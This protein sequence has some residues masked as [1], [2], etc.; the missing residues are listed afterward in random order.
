[1]HAPVW[2]AAFDDSATPIRFIAMAG[3]AVSERAQS[4]LVIALGRVSRPNGPPN[5]ARA[6]AFARDTGAVVWSA[7][8]PSPVLD[9]WSSPVIDRCNGTVL[10]ASNRFLTA[11]DLTTG[12]QL[13]QRQLSRVVVNASP[14]VTADLGAN[15]RVFLTDYH[16][17]GTS[18]RLYAINVDPFD[19]ANNPFQP[20]DIVWSVTIGGTSGNTPAYADGVVYVT[21]NGRYNTPPTPNEPGAI[22]AFPA[23]PTSTPAPLWSFTNP[24]DEGFY[25]GLAVAPSRFTGQGPVLYA[26]SYSFFDTSLLSSANLVKV[27]GLTG[28]LVWSTPANRSASIPVPLPD[29]R[30]LLAS[31]IPGGGFGSAVSLALYHD[32]GVAAERVWES[33]LST[34]SDADQDGRVDEGEYTPIGGW[35]MQP[36]VSQFGGKTLAAIGV[37]P[38][39]AI[40]PP[41]VLHLVDLDADPASPAFFL[42]SVPGAGGSAALAGTGLYSV[43]SGGL[44]AF[45]PTVQ[46]LDLNGDSVFSVDDLYAWESGTGEL[47]VDGNGVVEQ[48]DRELLL[49]NLRRTALS[50]TGG[51]W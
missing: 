7:P 37:L 29:G 51:E 48:A 3:V 19:P 38:P 22:I 23:L 26:A 46:Q 24:V 12:A 10:V 25:G 47:D 15:D 49:I 50:T 40:T 13:W 18:G 36:I 5:E 21:T 33:A 34:W 28:Q 41:E 4:N 9:S 42:A 32:L 44:C 30:V 8:V 14:V 11:L 27:D 39:D 17:G 16:G 20:G 2:C 45:G 43:G 35:T 1:M 6:F 31:G